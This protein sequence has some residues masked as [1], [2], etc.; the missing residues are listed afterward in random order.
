MATGRRE[1]EEVTD[2]DFIAQLAAEDVKPHTLVSLM[3]ITAAKAAQSVG[4]RRPPAPRVM[5]RRML[6]LV[7]HIPEHAFWVQRIPQSL[8]L[9]LSTQPGEIK[10]RADE[11]SPLY[12][13]KKKKK[14]KKMYSV[15][16]FSD[17]FYHKVGWP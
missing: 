6:G 9:G 5:Q 13:L 17:E 11:V 7:V 15:H 10:P 16:L 4:Q 8:T 14:K 12:S 1:P 3:G 2:S